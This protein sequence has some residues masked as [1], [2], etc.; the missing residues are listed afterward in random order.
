MFYFI[1]SYQNILKRKA[2]RQEQHNLS[3]YADKL[4]DNYAHLRRFKHDYQ[5]ILLTLSDYIAESDQSDLK[6]YYA[7]IVGQTQRELATDNQYFD[8]LERLKLPALRSLTY[9]KLVRAKQ[10]GVSACLEVRDPVT[11]VPVEIVPVVRVLGILFDNAIEAVQTQEDGQVQIAY[12]QYTHQELEIVVQNTI[13]VD[14]QIILDQLFTDGYSTKGRGRGTGL[15]TVKEIIDQ[16][17]NMILEVEQSKDS[18]RVVVGL[19]GV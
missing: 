7:Q 8:G 19:L 12:V 15:K 11:S 16:I 17:P 5:N 4:A 18:F 6:A 2:D 1:R 14:D 3:A 13:T 9:Q 10:A